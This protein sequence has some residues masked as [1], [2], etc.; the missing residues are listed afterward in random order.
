MIRLNLNNE[1]FKGNIEGFGLNHICPE[2]QTFISFVGRSDNI[3]NPNLV[4]YA[5]QHNKFNVAQLLIR[6]GVKF[7][8]YANTFKDSLIYNALHIEQPNCYCQLKPNTEQ[9]LFLKF[10][11]NYDIQLIFKDSIFL[12]K[13]NTNLNTTAYQYA[14]HN[15]Y[16]KH[17]C[18]LIYEKAKLQ[19]SQDINITNLFHHHDEEYYLNN[20]I[21]RH[22]PL[23]KDR[24]SLFK[25]G[26]SDSV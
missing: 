25:E 2:S 16:P 22:L 24:F 13:N 9:Y 12:T 11:L 15:Y 23:I 20:D 8:Y 3:N 6:N 5:L 26:N 21:S 17:I 19:G 14:I 4:K 10:I 7:N 1:D 18:N